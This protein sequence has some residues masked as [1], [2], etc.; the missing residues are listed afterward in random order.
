MSTISLA[1]GIFIPADSNNI[2]PPG[3]NIDLAQ[4]RSILVNLSLFSR[5]SSELAETSPNNYLTRSNPNKSHMT[6]VEEIFGE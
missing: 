3:Y 6:K 5:Y 2:D 4:F 1:D